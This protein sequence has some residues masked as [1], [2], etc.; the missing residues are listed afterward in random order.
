MSQP[1]NDEQR[2]QRRRWRALDSRI[3]RARGRASEERQRQ[4]QRVATLFDVARM[5]IM[6]DNG[7]RQSLSQDARAYLI[8]KLR[9]L[10]REATLMALLGGL[11]SAYEAFDTP[12]PEA[13]ADV[14]ARDA[15][16]EDV[17]L[18]DVFQ[19]GGFD[20][21]RG[22]RQRATKTLAARAL[23]PLSERDTPHRDTWN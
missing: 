2:E 21:W 20:L 3:A 12:S 10:R 15:M 5:E 23:N 14:R 16:I 6:Y 22:D 19:T 9:E 13:L 17:E 4:A 11:D 1:L 18:M 8:G 7:L